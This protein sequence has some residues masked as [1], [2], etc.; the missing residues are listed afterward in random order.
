MW[1][2]LTARSFISPPPGRVES[3]VMLLK[4]LRLDEIA[5]LLVGFDYISSL[6]HVTIF[7]KAQ[8]RKDSPRGQKPSP[9]LTAVAIVVSVDD[10]ALAFL[11]TAAPNRLL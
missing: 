1:S 5:L 9:A 2:Y 8:R 3:K 6:P 7:A 10:A 4:A 11:R